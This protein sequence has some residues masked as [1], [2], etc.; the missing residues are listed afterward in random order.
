MG[1]GLN[2]RE[3]RSPAGPLRTHARYWGQAPGRPGFA[4]VTI[5][6]VSVVCH[7]MGGEYR[8][9]EGVINRVKFHIG[10]ERLGEILTCTIN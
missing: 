3:E 4:D 5:A 2:A 1:L 8:V 6:S 7:N 9:T 10:W